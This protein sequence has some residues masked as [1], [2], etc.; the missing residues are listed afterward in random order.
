[1]LVRKRFALIERSVHVRITIDSSDALDDAL[2]LVGAMYGETIGLAGEAPGSGA[3]A[4][5]AGPTETATPS[6]ATAGS[7]APSGV[8]LK[9][10]GG[11]LG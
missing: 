10:L 3:G 11:G 7:K 1:M 5:P 9:F 2:R 6:S 4:E 8:S